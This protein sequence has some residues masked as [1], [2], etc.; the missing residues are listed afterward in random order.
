MD[1]KY[2]VTEREC[3]AIV[4]SLKKWRFYLH[5][6]AKFL[7]MTDHQSLHWL[8]NMKE[9]KG[10]LARWMVEIQDFDFMVE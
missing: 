10:R 7:V 2:T 9:P 8:M 3:L 6:G 5:G 4:H 1:V